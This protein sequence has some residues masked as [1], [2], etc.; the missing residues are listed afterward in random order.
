MTVQERVKNRKIGIIGMARSGIAAAKLIFSQ[1]GIPFVSDIREEADLGKELQTL[2][3]NN[4]EFET[5]GHSNRLLKSDFI[6]LSPGVPSTIDI[7]REII[8]EGIPIFSEIELSSWFCRGKIIAITGSNGKT[9]TTTL[10]GE[11]LK[12]AGINTEVCGNIGL[13]FAEVVLNVAEEGFAVVEI[14]SFQPH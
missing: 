2:K 10:I 1:G 5:G 6:I 14:S 8:K 9:T 4:I 7:V 11:I 13:P 3:E 12:K